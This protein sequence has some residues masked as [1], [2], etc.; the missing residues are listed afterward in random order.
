VHP[1]ITE[2]IHDA[3]DSQLTAA[4]ESKTIAQGTVQSVASSSDTNSTQLSWLDRFS[5]GMSENSKSLTASFLSP[6]EYESAESNLFTK[7][8]PLSNKSMPVYPIP[9][10]QVSSTPG[11]PGAF[12]SAATPQIETLNSSATSTA[13]ELYDEISDTELTRGLDRSSFEEAFPDR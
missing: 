9:E 8:I 4:G 6:D 5:S 3:V 2:H 12:T 7:P 1:E 10:A 11:I 13:G